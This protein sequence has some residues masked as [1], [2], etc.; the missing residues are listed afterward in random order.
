[1]NDEISLDVA[2][3]VIGTLRMRKKRTEQR[4]S[5]PRKGKIEKE[6]KILMRG[7]AELPHFYLRLP[8][9]AA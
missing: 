9:V 1:M 5:P 2:L 7:A 4:N 6:S 3:D 8:K